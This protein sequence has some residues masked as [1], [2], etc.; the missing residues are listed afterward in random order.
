MIASELVLYAGCIP[1]APFPDFVAA[2][3]SA[4]FDAVSIWPVIYRRAMSR[5]GL[6]PITMRRILD[7][8]G[9][10]ITDVDPCG[11][12]LP[13]QAEVDDLPAIFRSVWTRRDFFEAASALG[14]DTVVAVDLASGAAGLDEA[15][16]ET[17][18]EGFGRLCDDAAEHGLQVALEFMPFSRIRNLASGWRVVADASRSNGGLILDTCHLARGG[19]DQPL[20]A[21]IPA[22]R[23]F[24]VQLSDG[25]AQMPDDLREESMYHRLE[26]GTGDFNVGSILT[27]LASIGVSTRVG[28][29]LYQ[30]PWSDRPPAQVAQDLA[31]STRAILGE[32]QRYDIR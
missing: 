31:A 13:A 10:R 27:T 14:A 3:A 19:W 29:E 8:S 28:P 1:A 24:A 16:Y 32:T 18:V 15:G 4:G 17:A 21:T 25:P 7:D 11:D 30:R 2:A 23:I 12:W 20:L 5:E 6:D 22:H 9:V 26:P